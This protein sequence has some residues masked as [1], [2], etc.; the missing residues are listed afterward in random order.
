MR[1]PVYINDTLPNGTL[2]KSA[3]LIKKFWPGL[4]PMLL[5]QARELLAR[6]LG[7]RDQHDLAHSIRSEPL[8]EPVVGE[9]PPLEMI[10]SNIIKIAL[11]YLSENER[12]TAELSTLVGRLPL[13]KLTSIA[14]HCTS[15][16]LNARAERL[17][18][19][20]AL[21]HDE[22]RTSKLA[23]ARATMLGPNIPRHYSV[24][25]KAL[26][27]ENE[28]SALRVA[29]SRCKNRQDHFLFYGLLSGLRLVELLP[30][31][32]QID[33]K[34][35]C[36]GRFQSEIGEHIK[37]KLKLTKTQKQFSP[38]EFST[39]NLYIASIDNYKEPLKRHNVKSK[40]QKWSTAAGIKKEVTPH[41]IRRSYINLY[42]KHMSKPL[43]NP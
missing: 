32:K 15:K 31:L 5:L 33:N 28:M 39:E 13:N 27:S 26:L 10:Q 23:S 7:Y 35:S 19:E 36:A 25:N 3:R 12:N 29:A 6:G 21:L 40:L 4:K 14:S 24:V 18:A 2:A 43:P 37:F 30:T 9:C 8:I 16:N 34:Y 41:M 11:T 20:E 22:G 17:P 1:V 38:K 42:L